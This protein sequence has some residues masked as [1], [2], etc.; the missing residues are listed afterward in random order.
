MFH[1]V[2]RAIKCSIGKYASK[3]RLLWIESGIDEFE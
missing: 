3:N 1:S 2:L